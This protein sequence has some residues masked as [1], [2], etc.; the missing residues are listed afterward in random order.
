MSGSLSTHPR[1]MSF[2]RQ[3]MA[4][5]S[6][7]DKAFGQILRTIEG[8]HPIGVFRED[9]F[10]TIASSL[11]KQSH[12]STEARTL[13]VRYVS[14][15]L[16]LHCRGKGPSAAALQKYGRRWNRKCRQALS[17]SLAIEYAYSMTIQELT[18]LRL[19]FFESQSGVDG[20]VFAPDAE[21]NL[22]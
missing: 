14:E 1:G 20:V 3:S 6:A 11:A 12:D 13:A 17:R 4:I 5:Q 16:L 15:T 10:K 7:S 21:L 22:E 19:E 8:D 2:S 9:V 18:L